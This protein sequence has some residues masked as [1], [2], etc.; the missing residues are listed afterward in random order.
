MR[1]PRDPDKELGRTLAVV[2]PHPVSVLIGCI[3]GLI[4]SFVVA[5]NFGPAGFALLL[6]PEIELRPGV[7]PFMWGSLVVAL[8]VLGV[9]LRHVFDRAEL[10]RDGIRILG[11]SYEFERMGPISWSR[12]SQSGF[13]QFWDQTTARFRYDGKEV[14]IRTRYLQDL[15]YRYYKTY[16]TDGPELGPG[17]N[18]AQEAEIRH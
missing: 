16:G 4:M 15:S 14:Q 12:R 11:K 10:C 8:L 9:G 2:G 18:R 1:Q 13:T 17:L 3:P 7:R 5:S 6:H